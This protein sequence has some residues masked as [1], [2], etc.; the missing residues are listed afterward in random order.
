MVKKIRMADVAAEAGVS[1]Q[2]VSRAINDKDGISAETRERI[3]EIAGQMGFRPSNIARGLAT[4][5]TATIGLVVPDIAN[6]FFSEIARGV[7][8]TAYENGYR[9]FL[10]TTYEDVDREQAL[11]DSLLEHQVDG[12][13]LCSS[14]LDEG[15]LVKRLAEFDDVVLVNRKLAESVEGIVSILIDEQTAAMQAVAHFISCG[16]QKIAFVAGPQRSYSGKRRLD[17]F[18]T[19]LRAHEQVVDPALVVHCEPDQR[20]GYTAALNLFAEHG[21]VDAVYAYN[22]LVAVGVIQACRELGKRI[23]EDVALIGADDIPLAS[24]ITPALSTM[25]VD[26]EKIGSLAMQALLACMHAED[27]CASPVV[28]EP[29]LILRASA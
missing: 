3:L 15:E 25:G 22:D 5:R 19:G 10:C 29:A 6:P 9:V 7:E 28:L 23:P 17:G 21:D 14:R 4:Q 20:G 12:L 8:D 24:L 2:T 26:K 18:R 16:C 27:E 11:L 1:L 13:V